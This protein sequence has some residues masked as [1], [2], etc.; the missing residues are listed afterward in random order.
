MSWHR[1]L[2]LIFFVIWISQ[3]GIRSDVV[4][5]DMFF[6]GSV[7]GLQK[8]SAVRYRGVP[9]GTVKEIKIDPENVEQIRVMIQVESDVPIKEDAFGTLE[10]IGITGIT[11][12]Q[13][14]GG[15]QGSPPL[16]QRGKHNPEIPTRPSRFEEVFNAVPAVLHQATAL[17]SDLR[18]IFTEDSRKSI[19]KTFANLQNI[20]DSL[21]KDGKTGLSE[22]IKTTFAQLKESLQAFEHVANEI[23]SMIEENQGGFSRFLNKGAEALDTIDRVG[24]SLEISPY[25]FLTNDPQQGVVVP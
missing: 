14:N 11:Y 17:I 23:E 21:V 3:S 24:R 12:V 6:K 8:G 7:T 22:S 9:V 16:R 1:L 13:I 5:Y 18:A 25:R 2:L 4:V 20:T 19:T 10:T 15:S